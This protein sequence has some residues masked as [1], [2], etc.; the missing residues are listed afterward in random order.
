MA[1]KTE[2]KKSEI[3]L[4]SGEVRFVAPPTEQIIEHVIDD[5][6]SM[7]VERTKQAREYNIMVFWEA[8]KMMRDAEKKYKVN[9]TKLIERVAHDNRISGRQMGERNLWMALKI[10][11]TY[12]VFEKVF[13]TEYGENI[14]LSK[15]KKELSTP[16]A[17]K[18]ETLN[19]IAVKIYN[20]LGVERTQKL[21]K[22]LQKIL[23]ANNG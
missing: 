22:E 10:N 12:P 13:N 15:L 14:S 18:E 2:Q 20:K 4:A 3:V 1:K 5:L 19:Q 16:K 6:E 9:I 21:V 7:L 17:K 23:E 11:D 8:G